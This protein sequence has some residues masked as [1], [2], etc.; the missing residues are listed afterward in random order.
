MMCRF[1]VQKLDKEVP[2][3]LTTGKME[4]FNGPKNLKVCLM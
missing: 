4:D 3:I 2:M 1:I